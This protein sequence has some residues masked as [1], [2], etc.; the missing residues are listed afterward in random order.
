MLTGKVNNQGLLYLARFLRPYKS[1]LFFVFIALS[2]SALSVLAIGFAIRFLIDSGFAQSDAHLLNQ[3]VSI[4]LFIV[5]ILSVASFFRSYLI[6]SICEKVI[7]DIRRAVYKKLIYVSPSFYELQKTSDIVSR[8]TNDTTLIHS[9][10]A[11]VFSFFLRNMIMSIGGMIMLFITSVKLTIYVIAILPVVIIPIIMIGKNV[12]RLSKSVQEKVGLISAHIEE[13]MNGIKTVQ[14]Y[15][16][17]L[18]EIDRFGVVANSALN[19]ALS[20]IRIRSFLV[21]LVIFTIAATVTYVFWIG[22]RSV[23]AGEIS[24]GSL[25][26]FVF[27]AIIV[28]SS[29]GGL[30]EVITDFSKAAGAADRVSAL[31]F[32]T[33]DVVESSKRKSFSSKKGFDVKFKDVQFNYPSRPELSVLNKLSL[34]VKAGQ[35]VAV[36]GSSGAGKSTIFQLLLR[37]YDYNSGKIM[38]GDCDIKDLSLHDLRKRIALVTQEPVIFS[39]SAYDNILYGNPDATENQVIA[40]AKLAEI[41][42]FLISLPQGINSFLGEKGVRLSGGQKQRISIARAILKDPE[43]LLLDEA[44]NSLDSQNEA[45]VQKSL[46]KFMKDRTAIIIAHRLTTIVNVDLILVLDNGKIVESGTH[47]ELLAQSGLYAQLIS[48]YNDC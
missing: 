18:Y 21:G 23:L 40:A 19:T 42:D 32:V 34:M 17:E 25:A 24:S 1:N 20:R 22:G 3:A 27:Y 6:E 9:V 15:T 39:A 48:K 4:V 43:I 7:T 12:R 33:S 16:R 26:S 44:T 30:S 29:I 41:Y 45:L 35:R 46:S 10:I 13:T 2:C 38:I 8:L 47:K 11:N 31:L 14:C 5:V 36:V 37:F 28:A